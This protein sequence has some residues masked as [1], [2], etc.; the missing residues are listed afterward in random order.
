MRNQIYIFITSLIWILSGTFLFIHNRGMLNVS[1]WGM[2]SFVNITIQLAVILLPIIGL[3]LSILIKKR[4]MKYV[5]ILG[6]LINIY[7]L[8]IPFILF[9]LHYFKV[10]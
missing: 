10:N 6:C 7:Y 3:F 1:P 8:S 9:W 4:F 5:M 2:H